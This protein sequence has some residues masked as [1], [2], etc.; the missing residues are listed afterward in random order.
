MSKRMF[1]G[2][3]RVHICVGCKTRGW[4]RGL[5][6]HLQPN[7]ETFRGFFTS[8]SRFLSFFC[9]R[10]EIRFLKAFTGSELG[11]RK[12]KTVRIFGGSVVMWGVD[13]TF[14]ATKA[15]ASAR[16]RASE[17]ARRPVWRRKH[18]HHYSKEDISGDSGS[19]WSWRWRRRGGTWRKHSCSEFEAVSS[20][21]AAKNEKEPPPDDD[22]SSET[23]THAAR[24]GVNIVSPFCA[25]GPR[26]TRPSGRKC[27]KTSMVA[28][29]MRGDVE[30]SRAAARASFSDTPSS[31]PCHGQQWDSR[32]GLFGDAN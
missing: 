28:W 16:E 29:I 10:K 15:R 6:F 30:T 19:L 18:S 17:E 22:G 11:I 25:A 14:P 31:A 7:V 23:L 5:F 8:W 32:P 4:Q 27:K 2:G 21:F 12:K 13:N 24:V 20:W 26:R 1:S 9:S 3:V